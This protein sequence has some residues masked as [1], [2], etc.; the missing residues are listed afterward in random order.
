MS[1]ILVWLLLLG[2]LV[3]A[4]LLVGA[5]MNSVVRRAGAEIVDLPH[6]VG[7]NLEDAEQDPPF[8]FILFMVLLWPYGCLR[9][10]LNARKRLAS[11]RQ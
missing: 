5:F 3:I 8:S 6:G 11:Q 7:K 4:Y 9:A 1:M 10:Y 2:L